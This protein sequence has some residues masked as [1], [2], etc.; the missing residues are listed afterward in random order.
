MKRALLGPAFAALAFAVGVSAC[1]TMTSSEV[2]S[3][4]DD[5]LR[6][7]QPG[8]ILGEINYGDTREVDL[9]TTPDYRAFYFYGDRGDQIQLTATAIDATDPIMWFLDADFNTIARNADTRPTDSS[10]II[11]GQYLPKTGR[12]FVV[13]RETYHAPQAR[14]AISLRK[15][16][17]LPL[18][19]DP[20]G[21]G[22]WDS[23]CTDPPG[24]DPFDPA[25]CE[26]EDLTA[27]KA[28]EMFGGESGFRPSRAAVFYN[29][30]QCVAR[31][32]AE[33]DCSPWVYAFIMDVKLTSIKAKKDAAGNPDGSYTFASDTARKSSIDFTVGPAS[34]KSACLDGP[35]ASG[36]LSAPTSIDWSPFPDGAPGVC[37][38]AALANR[39]SKL[40]G[41]CGRFELPAITLGSGESTH[42]TELRPVLHAKF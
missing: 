25:S 38:T 28:K 5:A 20:N 30:R 13:F 42:Y 24:Y 21:E 10:S 18:E 41:T 9:T 11:S 34:L 12:Y 15:L 1:S 33:P 40:T 19:C 37:A 16:G 35:F 39:A 2:S 6:A 7:L 27:D 31:P 8:E 29:T 36:P 4:S 14:F 17:V 22:T 23:S 3:T 32:G 26:G